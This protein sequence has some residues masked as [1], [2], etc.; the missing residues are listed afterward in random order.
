MCLGETGK[1]RG[2]SR[3]AGGA[4]DAIPFGTFQ[5]ISHAAATEITDS[6]TKIPVTS[7]SF[8]AHKPPHNV[9]L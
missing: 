7:M 2:K 6:L 3:D 5:R 8:H 1:M 4:I 9:T